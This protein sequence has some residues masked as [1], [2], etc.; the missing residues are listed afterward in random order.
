[1]SE[2]ALFKP[3]QL[4]FVH[5][6]RDLLGEVRERPAMWLGE[7]SLTGLKCLLFGDE[8]ACGKHGITEPD[9]LPDDV[10][11]R[12][13]REWLAGR[14]DRV[15]WSVDWYWLLIEHSSSQEE[16]FDRFFELLAEYEAAV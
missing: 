9:Q 6:I 1:M 4:D 2:G 13:F 12:G 15:G 10:P 5:S 16:A 8:I 14:Y 3:G 7:K 11:W